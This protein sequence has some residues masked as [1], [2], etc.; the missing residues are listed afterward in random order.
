MIFL[1][2]IPNIISDRCIKKMFT[3]NLSNLYQ[4]HKK[5]ISIKIII[6]ISSYLHSSN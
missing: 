6:E 2:R 3:K 1:Y 5:E 4:I